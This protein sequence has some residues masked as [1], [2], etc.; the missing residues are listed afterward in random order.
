[1]HITCATRSCAQHHGLAGWLHPWLSAPPL[2]LPALRP[3]AQLDDLLAQ[4]GLQLVGPRAVPGVALHH[5]GLALC[6]V[7]FEQLRAADG[8]LQ[9]GAVLVPLDSEE[10]E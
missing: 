10:E 4:R 2:T 8:E 5:P 6:P 3:P 1:M 9:V 7:D